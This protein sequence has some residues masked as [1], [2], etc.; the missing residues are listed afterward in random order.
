MAAKKKS[1]PSAKPP[2]GGGGA[3]SSN[4]SYLD[5]G[6]RKALKNVDWTGVGRMMRDAKTKARVAGA[7]AAQKGAEGPKRSGKVAT[8]PTAKRSPRSGSKGY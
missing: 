7:A 5:A 4:K 3:K 2:A 8:K 1:A 6:V